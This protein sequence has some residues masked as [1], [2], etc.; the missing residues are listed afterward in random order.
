MILN[1]RTT[2]LAHCISV[3]TLVW[4]TVLVE[5]VLNVKQR[6]IGLF[7]DVLVDGV[8][9]HLLNAFNVGLIILFHLKVIGYIAKGIVLGRILIF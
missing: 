3:E 7:A 1:A 6:D 4:R 9:V 8:E 5:K 2:R